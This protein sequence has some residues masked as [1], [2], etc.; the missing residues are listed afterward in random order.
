[1]NNA[2]I[3][4]GCDN[5]INALEDNGFQVMADAICGLLDLAGRT[6]GEHMQMREV[7]AQISEGCCEIN[8]PPECC[9]CASRLATKT[10]LEMVGSQ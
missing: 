7:L 2:E 6:A 3:A 4:Y 1:M 9:D 5:A 8:Y 10:L